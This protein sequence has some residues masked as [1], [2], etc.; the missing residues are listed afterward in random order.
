MTVNQMREAISQV[1]SGRKWKA[2][3]AHMDDGQVL[4]I[5]QDFMRK[6]KFDICRNHKAPLRPKKEKPQR[7]IT[8]YEAYSGKQITIDELLKEAK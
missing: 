6:G 5:Y 8:H 4:A 2:R 1:Y 3:V 7:E